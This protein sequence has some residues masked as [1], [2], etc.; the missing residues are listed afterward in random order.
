MIN[1][2][3]ELIIVV[4]PQN[5]GYKKNFVQAISLCKGDIIFLSDQDDVW[6]KDKIALLNRAFEDNKRAVLVFH[7]AI[8]VDEQLKLLY[9]SFW[10]TIEFE[11]EKFLYHDYSILLEK[12]IVQG[13]ACAFKKK[14]FYKALPF[15]IAANHDEWL[16]LTA[17]AQGEVVPVAEPLMKYRQS[18]ANALGGLPISFIGKIKNW[19]T[20]IQNVVNCHFEELLR[21][22]AFYDVYG[23]KNYND[24]KLV[25]TFN[26][27]SCDKFLKKRVSCI[28]NRDSSIIKLFPIYF[29][30]YICKRNAIKTFLRDIL[31]MYFCKGKTL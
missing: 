15:P 5:I 11:P 8:L 19:T 30:M 29:R 24:G 14:L 16:V 20:N 12:N 23:K 28:E 9:K 21:R 22:E 2:P 7:D 25:K 4:N 6:A 18:S 1:Y 3:G 27:V 13:S 31:A 17:I 26:F 10:K